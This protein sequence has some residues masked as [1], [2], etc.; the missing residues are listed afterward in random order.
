MRKLDQKLIRDL[1]RMRGQAIAILLVIAAG[2]GTFVMSMCAYRSLE[3]SQAGYYRDSRFADVFAEV[4]RAPDQIVRR[5][6]GISG[7]AAVQPRLMFDVLLDMPE[8]SQP[9]TARLI[10]IPE[11]GDARLNRLMLTRGRLPDAQRSGE[12]VVS[13]PFA[14]AHGLVSGDKIAAVINGKRQLLQIVGTAL[15]PEYVIEVPPG[16]L[17]PDSKRYG[18]FWLNRRELEAAFDMSGAFNS[19]SL[20]LAYDGQ[21]DYVLDELD[22]MLTPYGSVGAYGREEQVSHQYLTDELKQLRGMA[23]MAPTIFLSVAAFLLNM[24]ISRIVQQQREQIA[25]LKAFGY[26]DREVGFHYLNLVLVITFGGTLLGILFGYW[27]ASGLMT[28]YSEVY[29]F[30]ELTF[31]VDALSTFTAVLLTTAVAIAGT[32]WS[33]GAAVRLPPAEAMRPEAPPS[34][35]PTIFE[36]I[37]P[38]RWLPVEWRMVI[39]SVARRPL[40]SA[41]SILGISL[42][43]AV[44]ISGNFSMD[45][46][47]YLMDFQ[48]R[49]AQR[50]DLTVTFVEPASA[51]ARLEVQSIEGVLNSEVTRSVAARVRFENHSRRVGIVGLQKD[52]QLYRLLDRSEQ[53]V[54]VPDDGIMLNTKLAELLGARLGDHV[55]VEVLE[56]KRPVITVEVTALVEEYAGL[57]AYMSLR[58]LHSVLKE[59]D[60]VTGVFLQVDR[61]RQDAV[62]QS[63]EQRPAVGS[64]V[65]KDTL[66]TSFRETV[67]ENLL[68]MRSF[69]LMFAA[70]IAVGVVY[71]SARISLSER[72]RDLATMRVVGFSEREVSL[73]L[74]GEIALLTAAAIPLGWLIG[75]GLA[76]VMA[77]GMDT[78]QYRLPLV[79]RR[80][81]FVLAAVVVVLATVASGW[82]VQR[83]V[84]RLD[85][86]EVL[87]TR[88]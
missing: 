79:V 41:L 31:R 74:L 75:Y 53:V 48:F 36:K 1:V 21:L 33:V 66:L 56:E 4:R 9:A 30:P 60:V 54:R 78:E 32:W 25:A 70:I 84:R 23:V 83:R 19:V 26:T 49:K 22:R 24:V 8:M 18:I 10:S 69:I 7:V 55:T 68:V 59:S 29:R 15:S 61:N 77:A 43:V 82:V 81:T 38:R 88:E 57:N 63:L 58:Q 72:G 42:A 50:Q 65:L 27:M 80:D 67:G 51:A 20:K 64:V 37:L 85:L 34:F 46:I 71:N 47:E 76:G 2:V 28:M 3:T 44:I 52:P 5:I 11:P 45:A 62:F 39:R 6:Q 73:V 17:L 13:E 16:G 12:V 40:K 87:K 86:I 35:R 14:E